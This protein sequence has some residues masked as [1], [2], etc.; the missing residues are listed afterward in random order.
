MGRMQKIIAAEL[1]DCALQCNGTYL[2]R[3]CG[4]ET[5]DWKSVRIDVSVISAPASAIRRRSRIF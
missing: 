5:I 4:V 3:D 2:T 1:N